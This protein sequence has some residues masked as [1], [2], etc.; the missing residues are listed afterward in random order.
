MDNRRPNILF[1]FPDQH[2]HDWL[3]TNPE[4]PVRTPNLDR[5]S[6][7][8]ARFTN[9]ITPSPLCAPAR[10]CLAAGLEY[11][12]CGVPLN[13]ANYPLD[14]TTFYRRLRD[15]EYHVA[16]CGKFDL[17]KA[18]PDWGLDGK[19]SLEAW[20]FSDGI[21]N[22][23]KW[24]AVNSG[25][26]TPKD[27]YMAYLHRQGL[28]T[29]HLTDMSKRRGRKEATFPTSL[30][31]EAYCDNWV[32]NNALRLM[33]RFPADRPWFLQVNFTGPHDPWDITEQMERGW[34]DADFPQPNESDQLTPQQHVAIRQNYAAM[35]ENIDRWVGVYAEELKQRGELDNTLIVYSSDHGEMLGDH[36]L[37]AKGVPYQPSVGVPLI[38][39]GPRV[40]RGI[41]SDALI[42]LIDLTATFLAVADAPPLD[43]MD[44]QSLRPLLAGETRTHR[45]YV[46]SGLGDWR[47]VYDGRYKLIQ[48]FRETSSA[49]FDLQQDA[50]ENV[51]VADKAHDE[52]E[53]LSGLL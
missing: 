11:D 29:A 27:P 19:G 3:G 41:V 47:M 15:A 30:P 18:S 17:H 12:R 23:G 28:A 9:T 2:R 49:L 16:G 4:L 6:E 52:V 42:S 21:D 31:E 33:E 35:V 36:S 53:R 7:R 44:G 5:L 26:Q 46:K 10:A 25:G 48:G 45:E 24:D 1:L 39:A 34:R 50:R 43:G 38:I 22:A 37:W 8:G 13:R 40:G 51:N 20:G 32:G 14:Q